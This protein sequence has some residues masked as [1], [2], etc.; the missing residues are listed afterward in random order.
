MA[1]TVDEGF[2]IFH[3]WLT[4]TIGETDAAKS[5][6]ASVSGSL[7]NSL[8]ISRFFRSGSFGNGT[9]VRGYS[10]VDFFAVIP[11]RNIRS[12]AYATLRVVWSALDGRFP[13]T[14]VAIRTPAVWLPFGT[15]ASESTDV[16]PC[17]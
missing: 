10:D 2:R 7:K 13:N 9:S 5:H 6:R 14:G 1:K 15:D 3:S 4:P 11:E 8:E 17:S 12:T 16:V